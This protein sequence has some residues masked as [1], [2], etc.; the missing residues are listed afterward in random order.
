MKA[1]TAETTT[2][3][4]NPTDAAR[5]SGT[6]FAV[7]IPRE[8]SSLSVEEQRVAN[9]TGAMP[10]RLSFPTMDDGLQ[11]IR[12]AKVGVVHR[13]GPQP[14]PPSPVVAPITNE[15]QLPLFLTV[16]EA[17]AILRLPNRKALYAKI[18]RGQVEGVVRQGSKIL[19]DRDAFLRGLKR[20][21]K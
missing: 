14:K 5:E 18:E 19:F 7:T 21:S 10:V 13:E 1:N 6:I 11:F 16:E 12:D 17:A 20:G 2:P 9:E 4:P 15:R 8:H 3:D